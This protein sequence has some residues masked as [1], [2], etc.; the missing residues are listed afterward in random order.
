MMAE[1]YRGEFG[2]SPSL[3]DDAIRNPEL[4]QRLYDGI[5]DITERENDSVRYVGDLAKMNGLV[6]MWNVERWVNQYDA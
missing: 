4:A 6:H 1:K 3:L 2:S 5:P